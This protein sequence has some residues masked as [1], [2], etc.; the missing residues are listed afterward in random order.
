LKEAVKKVNL[1]RQIDINTVTITRDHYFPSAYIIDLPLDSVPDH[2]WQDVL[3]HEW[4]SSLHLWDRKLFIIGDRLRLVTTIDDIEPKL[5]W[6]KQV[7]QKTN[8]NIEEYNRTA[9]SSEAQTEEE[10]RR[11]LEEEGTDITV[12]RDTIRK[13]LTF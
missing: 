13:K 5:D 9:V 8:E 6:I 2:V 4:K 1:K 11:R 7:I 3:D 10:S 12:I